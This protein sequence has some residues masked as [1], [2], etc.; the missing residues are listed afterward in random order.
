M[1]KKGEIVKLS[2]IAAL[3]CLHIAAINIRIAYAGPPLPSPGADFS[4]ITDDGVWTWYGEPKAV[5]YEGAHR[6]TYMGWITGEGSVEVG[7][8]DHDTKQ[9]GISVIN[10]SFTED[11][12]NHPSIFMMPDGRLYVFYT[13]HNGREIR[14][15]KMVNPED[16]SE[17]TPEE[18]P[19]SGDWYCYPNIVFLS[20]EGDSGRLYV[21]SRGVNDK[22]TFSYSDDWGETWTGDIVYYN[23][24]DDS[25]RPYT[26][27]G[28]NGRDEIH[29]MIERAHRGG[30]NPTYYLRYK[31][32]NFYNFNGDVLSTL[33]EIEAGDPILDIEIDTLHEPREWTSLGG[34]ANG[35]GTGWDVAVNHEGYPVMVY[36]NYPDE[37]NHYYLYFRW[38]GTEWFKKELVNS[39]AYMGG[40]GGFAGGVTLDHE[41][42]DIV[43]MS[44]QV[45]GSNGR[46]HEIDQWITYDGGETWEITPIT[47]N[48][49]NKNCRPCVPRGHDTTRIQLMWLYGDYDA[50]GADGWHMAVNFLDTNF[51]IPSF[52]LTPGTISYNLA[53][54][55][56]A[57]APSRTITIRNKAPNILVLENVA[58]ST[59]VNW[60]DVEFTDNEGNEQEA[61]VSLNANAQSLG[62]GEYSAEVLFE[63]D[64]VDS[65]SITVNLSLSVDGPNLALGKTA[66]AST[67]NGSNSAMA[68]IDGNETTRW[69]SEF[70]DNQ[71]IYVD[72]EEVFLIKRVVI[73]WQNAAAEV[74]ALQV[75]DDAENWTTIDSVSDGSS[76]ELRELTVSAEGRYVR[77]YGYT[78]TTGYGQSVYEFEIYGE[79]LSTRIVPAKR[80]CFNPEKITVNRTGV[81]FSLNQTEE[82]SIDLLNTNGAK[83]MSL[84]QGVLSAGNH[85]IPFLYKQFS[86][87]VYILKMQ[88]GGRLFTKR[89]ICLK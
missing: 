7:Y 73:Q 18:R 77:I 33:A 62:A 2:Y 87:G 23:N 50:Y 61:V 85:H 83:V 15:H 79:Y 67:V 17:W 78:R 42:P 76:G 89:F 68:A 48:S 25:G 41:N 47:R 58:V 14:M 40:E 80:I 9:Y 64:N 56:V 31:D 49:A 11:D 16:I 88:K 45:D 63:A 55:K 27:Y 6:R 51:Q 82:V 37:D 65:R 84:Y 69:E 8:Y 34:T 29:M 10:P 71:W 5:Y 72:L 28:D 46:W 60:L 54:D 39:G 20:E 32:G 4:H 35:H 75:S 86:N 36:D 59:D 57:S 66:Q 81:N 22:P 19:I 13:G 1:G 52:I 30:Y 53:L 26:K 21:F 70:E 44:R 12:H 74:Y 43:Y 24:Q 38:T 3:F